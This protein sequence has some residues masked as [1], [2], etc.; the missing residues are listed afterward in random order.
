ME[1][2]TTPYRNKNQG[3]NQ[4]QGQTKLLRFIETLRQTGEAPTAF[5]EYLFNAAVDKVTVY[6]K[7]DIAFT[8]K[9]DTEIHVSI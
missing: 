1:R 6:S 2:A 7:A 4:K 9:S 5:D 8:F 3:Q